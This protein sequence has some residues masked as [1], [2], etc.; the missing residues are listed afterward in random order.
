MTRILAVLMLLAVACSDPVSPY[1][2]LADKEGDLT[3][4]IIQSG[5]Y[6]VPLTEREAAAVVGVE[7]K[8]SVYVDTDPNTGD[9]LIWF[10]WWQTVDY[11]VGDT[12]VTIPVNSIPS[13]AQ[14]RRYIIR[15]AE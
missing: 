14:Y 5:K 10:S 2:P 3:Q 6:I 12:G 15:L 7:V 13:A 1:K 8:W 4:C 9:L 11:E